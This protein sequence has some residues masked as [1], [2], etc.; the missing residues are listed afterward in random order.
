MP[1][2]LLTTAL[3][4]ALSIQA[5][6][7]S[8]SGDDNSSDDDS[9]SRAGFPSNLSISSPTS[10]RLSGTLVLGKTGEKPATETLSEINTVL[11]NPAALSTTLN[12]HEFYTPAGDA[13]ECY[14]PTLD[15]A[16]HPDSADGTEDGQLPGGDLGIWKET[17]SSNEACAA[18][19]LN[20]QLAALARQT[21]LSLAVLAAMKAGYDSSGS[22]DISN[23]LP[24]DV[25]LTAHT[26]SFDETN[27][28]SSYR[29]ELTY[30][31]NS[32]GP[33][34]T[35]EIDM[36]H[37]QDSSNDNDYEGLL[38]IRADNF[39][40]GGNC[41]PGN[42][43]ISQYTSVHYVQNSE[44]DL[45]VQARSAR[46]CGFD[47]ASIGG[48]NAFNEIAPAT[49]NLITGNI[50]D[51]DA[52]WAGNFRIFTAAFDPTADSN[53]EL[54]GQYSFTW[55]AGNMDSHS[56]VLD[57]GLS[58][59]QGGESW[60]GFG[61][62][63]QDVTTANEF[64]IIR[65]MICNWAGP[66]TLPTQVQPYAQRQHLTLDTSTSLYIPSNSAASDI[67]YAP[68]NSCIYDGA[69][70]S[71]IFW[72]DRNLNNTQDEASTDL[73]VGTGYENAGTGLEFDLL[74]VGNGRT[75]IWDT[76]INDRNFQLPDYPGN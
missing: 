43:D 6:S 34:E 37:A 39:I 32:D 70:G 72:Y 17:V 59:G 45:R 3:F 46:F 64:G 15:Y 33:K 40:N 44:N 12:M 5:C 28:L 73:L 24:S 55:Q 36:L 76:I 1:F 62:K 26:F 10:V 7:S 9:E 2:R 53:G 42:N 8:D 35:I 75:D 13:Q 51:P 74:E 29:V 27:N 65:G 56:R 67:T 71:A 4:I 58:A 52:N 57:I 18:A 30:D 22:A 21:G 48:H 20:A 14:G 68:T 49:N 63:V 31:I 11:D 23:Y 61:D 60:F 41:G 16:D 25:T 66:K 47:S 54:A 69:T 38:T 50:L 19:Q